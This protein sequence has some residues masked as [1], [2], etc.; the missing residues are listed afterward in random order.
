MATPKE[1]IAE[2]RVGAAQAAPRPPK[3]DSTDLAA[4]ERHR[5]SFATVNEPLGQSRQQVEAFWR[6][7]IKTSAVLVKILFVPEQVFDQTPGP[8]A[9]R[10]L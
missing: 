5:D 9:G 7:E 2:W 1:R 3:P 6:A 10:S 8:G 4:V